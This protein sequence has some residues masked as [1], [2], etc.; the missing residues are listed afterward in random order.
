MRGHISNASK[1]SSSISS[2]WWGR[3]SGAGAGCEVFVCV[4]GC[5]C[6]CV[7][8]EQVEAVAGREGLA[9]REGERGELQE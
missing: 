9:G 7:C 3:E 6:V 1:Q 2:S 8:R 5:V 4:C